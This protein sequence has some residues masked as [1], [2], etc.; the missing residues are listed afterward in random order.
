MQDLVKMFKQKANACLIAVAHEDVVVQRVVVR[1][2]KPSLL[3]FFVS[4]N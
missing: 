2:C 4:S 3:T 1:S